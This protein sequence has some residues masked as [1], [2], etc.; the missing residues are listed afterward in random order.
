MNVRM[1]R[2]FGLL[3]VLLSGGISLWWGGSLGRKVH[4]GPIDFQA[5]YYAAQVLIQH[6][7]P[8]NVSKVEGLYRTDGA[9]GPWDSIKRRQAIT[10]CINLPR[11]L[12]F[13]VPLAMLP[14]AT[15]QLSWLVFSTGALI[16]SALLTWDLAAKRAPVLFACLIGFLLINC[17]VALAI[18]NSAGIVVGLCVIA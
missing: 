1:A 7:K 13:V 15:A 12:L 18:G 16:V 8:Y 5:V 2:R 11:P 10:L 4:G 6:H 3:L 9:E 14:L 17:Q